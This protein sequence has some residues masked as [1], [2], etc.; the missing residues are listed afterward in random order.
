MSSPIPQATTTDTLSIHSLWVESRRSSL[1]LTTDP[2]KAW[3]NS[4]G[5]FADELIDES[6]AAPN[7]GVRQ[8]A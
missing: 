3:I 5:M 2:V 7:R 6:L 4:F 8:G 1:S